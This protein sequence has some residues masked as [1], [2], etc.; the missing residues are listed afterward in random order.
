LARCGRVAQ[1][2]DGLKS[3]QNKLF[4][5]IAGQA[6]WHGMVER[7]KHAGL[8]MLAKLVLHT[9]HDVDRLTSDDSTIT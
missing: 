9:G 7:R 6:D 8:R 4:S 3:I 1:T 5:R 2:A